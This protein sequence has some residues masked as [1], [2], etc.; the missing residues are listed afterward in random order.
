MN[1]NE[2]GFTLIEL[3]VAVAIVAVITLGAG[4]TTANVIKGS[5]RNTDWTTAVCQAQNVG[6]WVSQDALMAQTIDIGDDP[7]TGDA[8][9]IVVSRKDWETG[10]TYDIRYIWFDSADSL[11]KLKRKQLTRDKYGVEIDNKTTLVADN[12]YSANLSWQDSMWGLT[13][14]AR[15]GDKSETREY[16]ISQRRQM[17][18]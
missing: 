11:N 2:N 18:E 7:E 16:F 17:I 14:E 9:F 10:N 12:I 3:A 8:E 4:M 6:Y 15:S 5:Q 13:V 1:L